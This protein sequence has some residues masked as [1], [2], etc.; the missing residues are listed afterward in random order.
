MFGLGNTKLSASVGWFGEGST[1]EPVG[2]FVGTSG[3]A[4]DELVD[5]TG[6]GSGEVKPL[7]SG[8][9]AVRDCDCDDAPDDMV[10]DGLVVELL[11]S[12][13]WVD[14][15]VC[16]S[17]ESKL[18]A[19]G[20]GAA[21]D[22]DCCDALDNTVGDCVVVELLASGGWAARDC[23]GEGALDNAVIDVGGSVGWFEGGSRRLW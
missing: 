5:D 10:C 17:V 18:T 6:C 16:D 21:R 7:A 8:G 4:G 13:E 3:G 15:T 1:G 23:A 2:W 14:N 9:G 12:G 20:G 19:S 22:S 11:P